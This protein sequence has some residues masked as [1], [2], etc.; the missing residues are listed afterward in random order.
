MPKGRAFS[1]VLSQCFDDIAKELAE[2][3]EKADASSRDNKSAMLQPSLQNQAQ[4]SFSD[5]L[6]M[7]QM[8]NDFEI[9]KEKNALKAREL[10]LKENTE[11]AKL[12]LS[13]KELELEAKKQADQ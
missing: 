4:I 13:N 8:K 2:E 9:E 7:M 6:K 1:D 12:K 3:N 11:N 5:Q 10:A